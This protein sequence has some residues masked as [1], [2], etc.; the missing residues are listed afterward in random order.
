MKNTTAIENFSKNK[1]ELLLDYES[2]LEEFS[3]AARRIE[4]VKGSFQQEKEKL[5]K[6]RLFDLSRAAQQQAWDA[7][8]QISLS[9]SAGHQ[10]D[11]LRDFYPTAVEYW[12][13]Y[14]KWDIAYDT[15]PQSEGA[16]VAHLP[17]LG[18][19]YEQANRLICFAILLGHGNLLPRLMP[20]V[21][22]RNPRTDG[23]LERLVA[24]FVP[25]RGTPPD[26]CTRHL[27]YFKT[28]K[29]FAAPK[30]KR[31]V[32]MAQYL[33]DWYHASRRETYHDSH[34]R[35][36]HFFGYWSWEAAAITFLL[37]ID[38]RS[39]ADAM[40][41]PKDLV[42]FARSVRATAPS[43]TVPP[44]EAR[45]LRAKAGEPC[46]RA[47]KWESIDQPSQTRTY[48]LGEPMLGLA[49]AYGLTVWRYIDG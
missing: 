12:E 33:G 45:E 22:Y 17:L 19:G 31:P 24:P 8:N 10:V 49:S 46:P 28:L 4:I 11:E 9:Y 34:E 39:Y 42:D 38:D 23:L 30:E 13:N 29:I 21:D 43:K 6:I 44:A 35:G 40:F 20:I 2:Y 1:R 3:S 25:G 26:D 27:P 15:S 36:T 18:P 48:A 5:E 37:D 32:M 14:A 47:G 41:Y 7:L 16:W